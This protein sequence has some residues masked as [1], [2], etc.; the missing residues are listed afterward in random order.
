MK[1]FW[2]K[3]RYEIMISLLI[4][5]AVLVADIASRPYFAVGGG[6][7]LMVCVIVYW[8]ALFVEGEE[9]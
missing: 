4:A 8:I 3:H 1:K 7:L 9:E 6:G 2:K 5:A